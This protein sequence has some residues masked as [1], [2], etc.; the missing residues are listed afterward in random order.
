MLAWLK[1][2]WHRWR[3]ERADGGA[4]GAGARGEVAAAD[5]L[6]RRHAY[7]V[8][9]RNWRNPRDRRQEID[10]VMRDGEVLVFVEVKARDADALVPG[11]DA[12]NE[13]KRKALRGA[14]HA[15]LSALEHPPR[16]FRFDVVE[17]TLSNRLPS[18]CHHFENVPLF[19]KGYHVAR[20]SGS[21]APFAGGS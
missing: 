10:L 13:R 9:A 6:Q 5:Y 8:V 19:P 18:Q 14:V 4:A 12:I 16:N 17:V 21:L 3:E 15:Y 1:D 11:Y 20:Q 7:S 2:V